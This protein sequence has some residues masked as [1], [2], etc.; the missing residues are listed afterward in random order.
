[1]ARRRRRR[2]CDAFGEEGTARMPSIM[3]GTKVSVPLAPSPRAV[4]AGPR[5]KPPSPRPMPKIAGHGKGCGRRC[6][7]RRQME[8]VADDPGAG[9]AERR[10]SRRRRRGPLRP[11]RRRETGRRRRRSSRKPRTLAGSDI[12]GQADAEEE[13]AEAEEI[14]EGRSGSD[15]GRQGGDHGGA[16]EDAGH[17]TRRADEHDGHADAVAGRASRRPMSSR[18]RQAAA[19]IRDVGRDGLADR[20]AGRDRHDEGRRDEADDEAQP[21]WKGAVPP[22]R[23][24][25][26]AMP[27]MP[28][29]GLPQ[30]PGERPP[31]RSSCRRAAM[32]G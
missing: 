13:E 1:M 5:A 32:R 28:R 16:H 10:G 21:G 8:P 12:P 31:S 27:E 17:A 14:D 18:I 2:W 30:H 6:P 23:Q 25:R 24:R 29:C 3:A 26:P 11:S 20:L 4:S 22:G 9:R 15:S 19:A 7:F